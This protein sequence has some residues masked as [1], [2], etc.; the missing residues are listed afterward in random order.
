MSPGDP[1]KS[2]F[3]VG[4]G[5]SMPAGAPSQAGI[6]SKIFERG[7]S[8]EPGI[9]KQFYERI[10]SAEEDE[11][12][13]AVPLEDVFTLLDRA[14]KSDERFDATFDRELFQETHDELIESIGNLFYGSLADSES[15]PSYSAYRT[16]VKELVDVRCRDQKA[17]P[18]AI[19]SLNWDIIIDHLVFR[20]RNERKRDIGV[21]YCCYTNDL[22]ADPQPPSIALKPMGWYNIKL[23]KLHGSLN[24]LLCPS[25]GRLYVKLDTKV[26]VGAEQTCRECIKVTLRPFIITPTLLKDLYDT[27]IKMVWHNAFLDLKEAKRVVFIGYS[28]PLADF[29]FRYTLAK[30]IGQ[31]A[32]IRVVLHQTDEPSTYPCNLRHL[33]PEARYR[34]FFGNRDLRVSY[35]GAEAFMVNPKAIWEW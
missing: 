16:F 10:F 12:I 6:V 21:D 7:T 23:M 11:E 31:D 22:S 13:A 29:E 1:N 28:F 32:K 17:D 34:N 27:H 35:E 25:C 33:S 26:A 24:W 30:A 3:V 19:I 9:L 15:L 8:R 2:V 5:F 4:A 18:F 14:L 20:T